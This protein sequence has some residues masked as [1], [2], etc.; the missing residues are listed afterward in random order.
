MIHLLSLTNIAEFANVLHPDTYTKLG[1]DPQERLRMIYVRQRGRNL[2]K[3]LVNQYRLHRSDGR[4]SLPREYLLHQAY[5]LQDA[6]QFAD[7]E[8]IGPCISGLT[9]KSLDEQLVRCVRGM[10]S[11]EM[12]ECT[13]S[14]MPNN[15]L[16]SVSKQA[17]PSVEV[18]GRQPQLNRFLISAFSFQMKQEKQ[19]T[20][21]VG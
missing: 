8:G 3:W 1:V 2:V 10:A 19:R 21:F 15:W 7:G 20:I 12:R 13:S 17:Q 16:H 14:F 5:A 9:R 18:F 4:N 6:R 11:R